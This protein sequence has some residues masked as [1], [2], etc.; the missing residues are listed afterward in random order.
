MAWWEM[1]EFGILTWIYIGEYGYIPKMWICYS[2]Y[3]GPKYQLNKTKVGKGGPCRTQLKGR[4]TVRL[5][6]V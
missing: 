6:G 2:L 5:L 4:T 1:V 3:Y